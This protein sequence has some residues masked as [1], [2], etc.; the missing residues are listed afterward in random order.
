MSTKLRT[1]IAS[2]KETRAA[3]VVASLTIVM[4]AGALLWPDFNA[5]NTIDRPKVAGQEPASIKEIIVASQMQKKTQEKHPIRAEQAKAGKSEN[6]GTAVTTAPATKEEVAPQPAPEPAVVKSTTPKPKPATKSTVNYYVQLG[7]F[8]ERQRAI[9]LQKKLANHWE[10][11][12]KNKK[13][14]MVAVWAGP[15]PTSKDA[16]T[17]M[18]SIAMRTKIKGFLVKH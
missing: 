17:A 7:A 11:I 13:N 8:K 3:W 4:V 15:Y 18:R 5:G 12:L 9:A 10:T 6:A 16:E 2:P 14:N 1:W